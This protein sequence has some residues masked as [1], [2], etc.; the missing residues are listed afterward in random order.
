MSAIKNCRTAALGGHVA[1][2]EDC[3]HEVIA[4]NSIECIHTKKEPQPPKSAL[5]F[6]IPIQAITRPLHQNRKNCLRHRIVAA[7]IPSLRPLQSHPL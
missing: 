4:Y 7:I 3:A 6:K 2:C 5:D 1:R